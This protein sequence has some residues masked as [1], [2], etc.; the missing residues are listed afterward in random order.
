M[1]LGTPLARFPPLDHH[2]SGSGWERIHGA[3]WSHWKRPLDGNLW[4]MTELW[5]KRP[6]GGKRR[7]HFGTFA[8]WYTLVVS[9]ARQASQF[10]QEV[11]SVRMIVAA[12]L[13]A[14]HKINDL[15]VRYLP[16]NSSGVGP[17][18]V[19]ALGK[20]SNRPRAAACVT[21]TGSSTRYA[22]QA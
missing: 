9:N 20:E 1:T 5:E 17:G 2:P 3:S 7:C 18:Q 22:H 12:S 13:R 21:G 19:F 11:H 4:P 8:N 16:R 6:Q 10:L 14:R 15:A